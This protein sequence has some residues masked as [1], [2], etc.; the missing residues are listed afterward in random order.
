[1]GCE[2]SAEQCS[3]VWFISVQ[4]SALQC[5]ALE[6]SDVQCNGIAKQYNDWMS[7]LCQFTLVQDN[8]R[9]ASAMHY[10]EGQ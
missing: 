6:C 1:M 7:V 10:E 8:V 9:V 5:T 4:Y 3:A 2:C